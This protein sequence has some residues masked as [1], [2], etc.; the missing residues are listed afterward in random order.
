MA[1]NDQQESYEK[2][3]SAHHGRMIDFLKFA[4]TKNAALLTFTSV[5]IG[6]IIGFLRAPTPLPL[7]YDK[8]FLIALPFLCIAALIALRSF[9]PRLLHHHHKD[10]DGAKNLL[11]FGDI[12]QMEPRL[13]GNRVRERYYPPEGASF[14]DRY[15]EDLTIQISIQ[16][17]IASRKFK[18]FNRA[19]W[20]V[21]SA[22]AILTVP[23]LRFLVSFAAKYS[24]AQGWL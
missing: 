18:A 19:A 15:L 13:Y 17:H 23:I 5:W 1:K 9:L 24:I 21:L 20:L 3:L 8:A 12:A 11:Y 2:I 10:D 22:F 16:A 4:E 6:S 14:T 7:D